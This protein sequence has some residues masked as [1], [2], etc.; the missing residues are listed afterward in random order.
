MNTRKRN[1]SKKGSATEAKKVRESEPLPS[2]SLKT[3]ARQGPAK[4]ISGSWH[5]GQVKKFNGSLKA[6]KSLFV[7]SDEEL[8][9]ENQQSTST[10]IKQKPTSKSSGTV[11][12]PKKKISVAETM[13]FV[14]NS[15]TPLGTDS[16]EVEKESKS[17]YVG[18]F[19]FDRES[20]EE[21]Q[22]VKV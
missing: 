3:P 18:N 8:I 9:S 21:F 20:G 6:A 12:Q 4:K 5:H 10:S 2:S 16:I 17:M 11:S 19:V 15:I 7:S 14:D 13:N 1:Q 22:V